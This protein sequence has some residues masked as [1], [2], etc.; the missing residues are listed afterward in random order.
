M[1]G[2]RLEVDAHI[3]TGQSTIIKNIEKAVHQAG[4]DIDDIVPA[5]L[6]SA[7]AV[8]SRRQK[9]LGVVVI[10]VGCGCTSYICI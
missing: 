9:E 7:E 2:V 10:D 1:I 5:S 3:I 4:V 6:A 8:L